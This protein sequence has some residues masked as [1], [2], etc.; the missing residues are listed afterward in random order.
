MKN[1]WAML[2]PLVIAGNLIAQ[3]D[4]PVF[5]DTENHWKLVSENGDVKAYARLSTCGD[6]NTPVYLVMLTNQNEAHGYSITY[7]VEV[8]NDLSWGQSV[9]RLHLEPAESLEANC[10]T[11]PSRLLRLRRIEGETDLSALN[12]NITSTNLDRDEE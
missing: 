9:K 10:S 11:A 2:I 3:S 12:F 6:N 7:T 1:L 8:T 5:A 4:R